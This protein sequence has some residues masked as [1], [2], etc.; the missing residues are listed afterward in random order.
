MN[1]ISKSIF[2]LLSLFIFSF[3]SNAKELSYTGKPFIVD[4]SYKATNIIILPEKV[5]NAYSSTKG[6]KVNFDENGNRLMVIIPD[7]PSD[8]VIEGE[9]G[10]IY[11]FNMNPKLI[12][13][14]IFVVKNKKLERKQALVFEGKNPL[15]DTIANIIKFVF[16]G[17]KPP[18]YTRKK[19]SKVLTTKDVIIVGRS[20]YDGGIFRVF[21]VDIVNRTNEKL[22]IREDSKFAL[23]L[24]KKL[25]NIRENQVRAIAISKEF[26]E[27]MGNKE[28]S[29][30][31][32][33]LVVSKKDGKS[34]FN[35]LYKG[36]NYE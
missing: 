20:L 34:F 7:I 8:L 9:S 33:Y 14:Q 22:R 5:K 25:A 21:V 18:G 32:Y 27:P 1:K 24:A 30:A 19:F 16:Q 29:F 36:E 23:D 3:M 13:S 35:A 26:L 6:V 11:V 10:N 17:E 31:T 2:V 12:P 15:E 4:A 28:K